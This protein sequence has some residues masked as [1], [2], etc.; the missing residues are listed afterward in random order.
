MLE[1]ARAGRGRA[2]PGARRCALRY[3]PGPVAAKL[4][5]AANV[6]SLLAPQAGVLVENDNGDVAKALAELAAQEAGSA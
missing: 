3:G 6:E 5:P 4:A 2:A 1:G